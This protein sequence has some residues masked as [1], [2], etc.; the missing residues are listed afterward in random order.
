MDGFV[1][2][3]LSYFDCSDLQLFAILMA[4]ILFGPRCVKIVS[5]RKQNPLLKL[6][7]ICTIGKVHSNL[8]RVPVTAQPGTSQVASRI[9]GQKMA[10]TA[11]TT[12]ASSTEGTSGLPKTKKQL[13]TSIISAF[14]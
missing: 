11:G 9:L 5:K 2:F 14:S 3:R 4:E 12:M 10:I 7:R 6:T 8:Q 13:R 1:F